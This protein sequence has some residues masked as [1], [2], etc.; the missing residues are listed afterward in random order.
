M[1]STS[2]IFATAPTTDVARAK[3]FYTEKVGLKVMHE[4][5]AG[6]ALEA[7]SGSS[8]YLYKRAPSKADHTVAS[9]M[10]SDIDSEVNELRSKGVK[11]EDYNMPGLTTENGIATWGKDKAAWFKDPDNNII[12]LFQKG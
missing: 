10:V 12:G 11:F 4:D 7:G 1:L 5:E 6:V 2:V 9:F 3:E 8:I